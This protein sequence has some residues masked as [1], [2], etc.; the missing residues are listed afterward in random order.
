MHQRARSRPLGL[1]MD[2]RLSPI[3]LWLQGWSMCSA[4]YNKINRKRYEYI[5]KY[6]NS[7]Y[8]GQGTKPALGR[9]TMAENRKI[10]SVGAASLGP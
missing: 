1:P 3:A 2:Q 5:L 4:G 6:Q 7:T 9:E 8:A 10:R